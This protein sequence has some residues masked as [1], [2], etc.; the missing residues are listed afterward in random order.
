MKHTPPETEPIVLECD[1]PQPRAVV[2]RALTEQDLL[3]EWLLPN[4]LHPEVGARF[5]FERTDQPG[6]PIECE[7]LQIEPNRTFSWRQTEQG[8]ADSGWQPVTSV[9]TITLTDQV[10]GGTHLQLMHDEFTVVPA[11]MSPTV[12][13]LPGVRSTVTP[14][15]RRIPRARQT[16][17]HVCQLRRAA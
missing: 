14:F 3:S 9:V 13:M 6:D 10:G 17:S 16:A 12:A 8:D 5:R 11:E 2:W 15:R 4:D 7:V 1:L